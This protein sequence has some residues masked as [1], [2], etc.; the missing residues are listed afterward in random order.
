MSIYKHTNIYAHNTIPSMPLYKENLWYAWTSQ[1]FEYSFLIIFHNDNIHF[2]NPSGFIHINI[3]MEIFKFPFLTLSAPQN[4]WKLYIS[5]TS[6]QST[7]HIFVDTTMIWDLLSYTK[8]KI[9]DG[10][11]VRVYSSPLCWLLRYIQQ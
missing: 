2:N 10:D 9:L 1:I 4:V 5:S 7:I 6:W 11:H 8:R 3:F